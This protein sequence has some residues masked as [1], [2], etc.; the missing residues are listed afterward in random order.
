MKLLVAGSRAITDAA[1]VA[2]AIEDALCEWG[3]WPNMI[4]V[5]AAKQSYRPHVAA[6][7]EQWG[8]QHGCTVDVAD[9]AAQLR[10]VTHAL[11]LYGSDMEP[12]LRVIGGGVA[13]KIVYDESDDIPF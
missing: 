10:T 6:M 9:E 8:L 12:L 5:I 4:L 11:V 7:A 13:V 2:A 1:F 3:E